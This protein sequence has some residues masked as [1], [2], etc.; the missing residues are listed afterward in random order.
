MYTSLVDMLNVYNGSMDCKLFLSFFNGGRAQALE[1]DRGESSLRPCA[2]GFV[3]P[4]RP[5]A[6]VVEI[7]LVVA[8][9]REHESEPRTTKT[10]SQTPAPGDIAVLESKARMDAQ[11]LALAKG[12]RLGRPK[13]AGDRGHQIWDRD[14]IPS[15]IRKR[16]E[17]TRSFTGARFHIPRRFTWSER[18]LQNVFLPQ[19]DLKASAPVRIAGNNPESIV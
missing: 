7:D 14:I 18:R 6:R 15:H 12:N 2:L 8:L 5:G 13:S 10:A 9:P 11:V 19:R 1:Y 17:V 4:A 3:H 16:E